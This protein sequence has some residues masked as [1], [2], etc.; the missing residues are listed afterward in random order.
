MMMVLVVDVEPPLAG[1][2]LVCR[3]LIC[4]C[5]MLLHVA[6]I[7]SE[8]F[9]TD[10]MDQYASDAA[11]C[12]H[13][14]LPRDTVRELQLA[15]RD[16]HDLITGDGQH[17][18]KRG[19]RSDPRPSGGALG[20]AAGVSE[21]EGEDAPDDSCESST[22]DTVS[23]SNGA[24]ASSKA[25]PR[26]KAST[27]CWRIQSRERLKRMLEKEYLL[28][29]GNRFTH[30]SKN[31]RTAFNNLMGLE[32]CDASSIEDVRMH[33]AA[34][35]GSLYN[36]YEVVAPETFV[37]WLF[38]K[39]HTSHVRQA[40]RTIVENKVKKGNKSERRI[41][42]AADRVAQLLDESIHANSFKR[43]V[44]VA[45]IQLTVLFGLASIVVELF[46]S[47]TYGTAETV[48]SGHIESTVQLRGSLSH[49]ATASE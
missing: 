33:A 27:A 37:E 2:R 8:A 40:V 5:S 46:S 19:Q 48:L 20:G 11:L 15:L 38:W 47:A 28:E 18:G 36:W 16:F 44:C 23:D 41:W 7:N 22:E 49:N 39:T 32:K 4:A 1:A 21:V 26:S 35:S 9:S 31:V 6:M 43:R 29:E 3:P 25:G 17:G 12:C 13:H 34:L 42:V 14:A 30:R 45:V 10:R 24:V